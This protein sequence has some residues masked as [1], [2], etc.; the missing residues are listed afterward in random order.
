MYHS[1]LNI[2]LWVQ[3]LIVR[4]QQVNKRT[5]YQNQFYTHSTKQL[6]RPLKAVVYTNYSNGESK[7]TKNMS[8]KAK[9]CLQKLIPR[10]FITLARIHIVYQMAFKM[11]HC[12]VQL[13]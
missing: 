4:L 10:F 11:L 12:A 8:P 5:G 2:K 13:Y 3:P 1:T 9:T 7:V 6:I